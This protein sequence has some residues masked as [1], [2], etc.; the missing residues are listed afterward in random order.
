MDIFGRKA[1]YRVLQLEEALKDKERLFNIQQMGWKESEAK[2][3][4]L[5]ASELKLIGQIRDMD[6][7][8]FQMAQ[9]SSFEQMRPHFIELQQAAN[10]RM[11]LESDRIKTVLIPEMKKAYR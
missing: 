10:T 6:Q 11:R 4:A 2:I 1:K 3:T 5:E 9:C 7:A 8:I